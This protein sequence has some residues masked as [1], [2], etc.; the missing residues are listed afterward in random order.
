MTESVLSGQSVDTERRLFMFLLGRTGS[1]KSSV[2][3]LLE[4]EFRFH[5]IRG[6][7]LLRRLAKGSD[8]EA[9]IARQA[10]TVGGTVPDEIIL[11]L[12]DDELR[13]SHN[14][15]KCLDGNPRNLDHFIALRTFFEGC[16][17]SRQQF[18]FIHLDTERSYTAERLAARRVCPQC[19]EQGTERMCVCCGT[20]T[21]QRDDD[22]S[23][24][25]L[26]EKHRWFDEEVTPVIA[27][28]KRS[29]EVIRID[30]SQA[31]DTVAAEVRRVVSAILLTQDGAAT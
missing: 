11:R 20:T 14:P 16:G 15:L 8:N 10:L 1:G 13:S 25:V 12:Y 17:F 30:A 28:L 27:F 26:Q 3:A 9:F 5:V 4:R 19:G 21:V 31:A 22:S 7:E 6:G 24:T 29:N 18:A 23:P 2:S